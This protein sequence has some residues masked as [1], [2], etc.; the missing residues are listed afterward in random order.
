M[1]AV[2][3]EESPDALTDEELCELLQISR[4]TLWRHLK[5]A[6]RGEPGFSEIHHVLV[7]GQRRWSR[8]SAL[9]FVN[10]KKA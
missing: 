9:A 1:V 7:G 4:Q 5:G 2:G 6:S 3:H 10:G 8:E